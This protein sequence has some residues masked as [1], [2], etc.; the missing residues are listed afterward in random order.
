MN[1]KK[2]N[3]I[4]YYELR[5]RGMDEIEARIHIKKFGVPKQ[6]KEQIENGE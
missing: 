3:E 6:L 2:A 1:K 4:Y 5:N